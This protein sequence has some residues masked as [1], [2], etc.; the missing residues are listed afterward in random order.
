MTEDDRAILLFLWIAV[1]SVVL[2]L[3]ILTA[4]FLFRYWRS[5]R[6][7]PGTTL[8]RALLVFIVLTAI[9]Q[10]I[11]VVMAVVTILGQGQPWV[12]LAFFGLFFGGQIF[13][14]V[15]IGLAVWL[16]LRLRGKGN[17]AI[18]IDSTSTILFANAEAAAM[19]GYDSAELPGQP[20][21][22]LMPSTY[23]AAHL[24]ALAHYTKTG[25]RTIDWDGLHGEGKHKR[26]FWFPITVAL[27]EQHIEGRQMFTGVIRKGRL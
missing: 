8:L 9:A 14:A 27:T 19:F 4:A 6:G 21:T 25:E 10:T 22:M 5:V 3:E 24:A 26:G 13:R 7:G 23:Q 16:L 15:A 12:A 2:L 17:A 18:T 1:P 20:L 11:N